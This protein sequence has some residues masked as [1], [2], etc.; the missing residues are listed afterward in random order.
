[1]ISSPDFEQ[2][3]RKLII[4]ICEV[5]YRHGF[6]TVSVGAIMRLVGV[7]EPQ[8]QRHDDELFDLD[9]EE[10]MRMLQQRKVQSTVPGSI[11]VTLH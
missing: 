10:F 7:D 2:Q 11:D 9:S 6:S 8:A 5:M 4:D 1:M 3:I